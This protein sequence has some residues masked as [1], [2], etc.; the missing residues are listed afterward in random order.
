MRILLLA[1]YYPAYL[2][3]FHAKHDVSGLP[4]AAAQDL[5]LNDYFGSWG[6]YRNHFR[7]LGHECEL[8]LGNDYVLQE[9]WVAESGERLGACA[10]RKFAVVMRQ[11]EAFRPDA[12]FTGSMFDY[13][14]AFLSA[15]AKLTPNVFA[16][17]AC[18]YPGNLDF[19][20]IRCVISS[21]DA[22]VEKFRASGLMSERLGAAF[23]PDI[24]ARVRGLPKAYDVTFIGGVSS[25][26]H[27]YRVEMLKGLLRQGIKVDIWGYG[28]DRSLFGNPLKRAF[29]GE[30]WGLG[31]YRALAQSRITLNFHID[32]A[33]KAGFAGNMRTF[34]ATGCGALLLTDS[35]EQLEQAF[36]PRLEISTFSSPA[37]LQERIGYFLGNEKARVDVAARGQERCIKDHGYEVR[38]REFESILM[39]HCV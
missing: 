14:G 22:F 4:Y 33:K 19:S 21:V 17:I 27:R 28:L 2:Q 37:Q 36:D 3:T 30:L 15:A 20:G 23:D 13:Y 24:A 34:E 25:R 8:I 31:Y 35:S 1:D 38:M 39:R 18:P 29:H 32:V 11:A 16:W 26:S 5:L 6:S 12:I 7:K 10:A 9:K